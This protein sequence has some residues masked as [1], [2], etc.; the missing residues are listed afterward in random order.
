MEVT[1]LSTGG[2]SIHLTSKVDSLY[3]TSI[4]KQ[5]SEYLKRCGVLHAS[6]EIEDQGAVPFVIAAG[7]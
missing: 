6:V 4:R 1:L 3:G 2:I 5:V 7:L